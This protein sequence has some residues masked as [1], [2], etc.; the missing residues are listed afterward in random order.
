MMLQDSYKKL[1]E[2]DTD[3]QVKGVY[4]TEEGTSL[5]FWQKEDILNFSYG[6]W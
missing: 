2:S 4:C 3:A 1:K 6:W 5:L